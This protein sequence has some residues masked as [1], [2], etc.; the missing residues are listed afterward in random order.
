MK[1][2]FP[3]F[4]NFI[5]YKG[6][7]HQHRLKKAQLDVKKLIMKCVESNSTYKTPDV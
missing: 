7:L 1:E 5:L 4:I 6:H 3:G 2:I